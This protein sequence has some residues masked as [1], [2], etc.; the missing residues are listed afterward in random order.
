MNILVCGLNSYL[1][2]SSLLY[3]QDDNTVV[4]GIVR[5]VNLLTKKIKTP[6]HA[7][8]HNLDMIRYNPDNVSFTL[9]A[10]EVAFY[11]T[12]SPELYDEIGANYELLSIR[13]FIQFSQRNLCNRIVYIGTI[14]DRKYLQAIEKLFQEFNVNYTIILKDIAIGEGTSFEDFMLKMLNRRFI[15]LYKPNKK[16]EVSPIKLQDLMNW[17]RTTDWSVQYLNSNIEF[18][19]N[20]TYEL[21][22]LMH[23]YEEKYG[24]NK[25]H[26]IV[27]IHNKPLVK[28]CNRYLSG[29]PYDQYAEYIAELCERE[30]LNTLS[31][32]SVV[33]PFHRSVIESI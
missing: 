13:N 22:E 14:Y 4:H 21:E 16:I 20:Q 26:T 29:I 33:S 10:C 18:K 25:R 5:D 6:I 24:K 2:K 8:L 15:Y 27:P 12:Q 1:G 28:W 19:G 31:W 32:D 30:E 17:L 11:F 9:P 3:L 23:L 7:Q